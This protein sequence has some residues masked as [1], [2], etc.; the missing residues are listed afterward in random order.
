MEKPPTVPTNAEL[1][2]MITELEFHY[3][4][5]QMKYEYLQGEYEKLHRKMHHAEQIA[6]L[7]SDIIRNLG[8][9]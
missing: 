3:K 9:R 1:Y 2:K 8:T 7:P 6:N 4:S 5:L